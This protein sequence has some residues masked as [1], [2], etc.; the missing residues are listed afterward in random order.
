MAYIRIIA[1]LEWNVMLI[2]KNPFTKAEKSAAKLKADKKQTEK[3][4]LEFNEKMA[5]KYRKSS[6]NQSI[7]AKRSK[8]GNELRFKHYQ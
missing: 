5:A 4:N 6:R 2:S 7:K 1:V 8:E 3:E